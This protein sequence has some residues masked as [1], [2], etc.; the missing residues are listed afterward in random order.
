MIPVRLKAE[1]YFDLQ[2]DFHS[3]NR[4]SLSLE[5]ALERAFIPAS[6]REGTFRLRRFL[7]LEPLSQDAAYDSNFWGRSRGQSPVV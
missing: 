3:G 7:E 2:N 1:N 5:A 6:S 4:R